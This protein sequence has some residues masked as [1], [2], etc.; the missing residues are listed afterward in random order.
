MAERRAANPLAAALATAC[1][2]GRAPVA[3]GTFGSLPGLV[4]AWLLFRSGG[5]WAVV[6]GAA[7]VT[8]AGAWAAG[9]VARAWGVEDPGAVVVDEVAGQMVALF[10]L[11]PT[12][13]VLVASFFLFRAFDVAKP[14]PASR[15]ERLPGGSGIM[16]DDLAAGAMANLILQAA[17]WFRPEWT[18]WLGGA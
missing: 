12:P 11:V 6:A 16:A 17:V 15:L 10:F 9:H 3:P 8:A 5:P 4:L 2:I 7:A 13:A 14:W 1:G 18:G